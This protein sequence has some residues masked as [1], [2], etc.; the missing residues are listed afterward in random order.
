L[1]SILPFAVYGNFF[2]PTFGITCSSS[3]RASWRHMT[4]R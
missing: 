1:A 3:S 4:S 2:F